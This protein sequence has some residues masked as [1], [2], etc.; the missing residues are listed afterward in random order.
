M[1]LQVLGPSSSTDVERPEKKSRSRDIR[2]T[3]MA[4]F[5]FFYTP[6]DQ[7]AHWYQTWSLLLYPFHRCRR[8]LENQKSSRVT[9][10]IKV[11]HVTQATPFLTHFCI[12]WL[13]HPAINP[14][15]KF[16]VSNFTQSGDMKGLPKFDNRPRDLGHVPTWPNLC[17]FE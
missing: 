6:D 12:F 5:W 17:I 16:E 15:T 8:G 11:G 3:L 4:Y 7:S 13:V 10:V 2:D 14:H 9:T 1:I